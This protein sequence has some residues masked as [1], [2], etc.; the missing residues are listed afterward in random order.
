M[1]NE[2]AIA[3]LQDQMTFNRTMQRNGSLYAN[4]YKEG[5][6]A[7]ELAIDALRAGGNGMNVHTKPDGQPLTLEQLRGMDGKPVWI[8][9]SPDWGHW[10]LSEDA[11]DYLADRDTAL[12][13]DTYSA[14]DCN[15]GEHQLRWIAYA[16][17]PAHIDREAWEPC[18]RCRPQ[19]NSLDRFSG[20]EF[21]IDDAEIYFYDSEDGWEG[22]EI[23]FCP[24]CGRPLT[25]AAWAELEKR[26]RGL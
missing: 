24:W 18:S 19:E 26:V 14:Q 4:Q 11:E 3:L 8:M 6:D 20:H 7:L 1:T 9:E 12:Y 17:P 25:E 23:R 22:E 16:Y 2:E 13:G 10:E 21:L 15:G 5:A